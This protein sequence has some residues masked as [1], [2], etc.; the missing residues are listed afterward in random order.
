[1]PVSAGVG[2]RDDRS[3]APSCHYDA[4]QDEAHPDHVE[5]VK[6]LVEEDD[7]KARA[8]QR[9]DV[10]IHARRRRTDK[11]HATIEEQIGQ[12]GGENRNVGIATAL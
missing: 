5:R 7:R 12:H 1:M 3:S 11:F 10:H 8:K 9:R 4:R 2:L 6:P